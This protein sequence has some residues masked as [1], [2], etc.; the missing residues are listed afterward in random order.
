[1][2]KIILC[3]VFFLSFIIFCGCQKYGEKN[4][5]NDLEKKLKKTESYHITGVLQITNNDDTYQYDVDVS[6]KKENNYK[7]SLINKSNNHEQVILKNESGVYVVTPSLNKSFKFQSDWP[8]NNSQIYLLEALIADIKNDDKR[9]FEE[10]DNKY[11]FTTKVNYPNNSQLLKQQIQI[12][13]DLNIKKVEVLNSEDIPQM[14]MQFNN[15]DWNSNFNEDYF[16]LDN[17]IDTIDNTEI[18]AEE[19]TETEN[20]ND[21]NNVEADTTGTIDEIIFPLYIP[22]GTTLTGQEKVSKADGE[23]IILTFDGEKPFLLVEETSTIE[24]EFNIIPTFGEPYLIIDT[25]GALTD[26]SITWSSNGIDYYIVSDAMSQTELI[27]IASSISAI[28]TI[29]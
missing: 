26:N 16:D 15:I 27:E 28:P 13:K 14:I 3:A 29:K 24:D 10:K 5:I 7:V 2:K 18:N 1:M 12:D 19:N 20:N 17:I 6:Y 23:R 4:I 21:E 22:S 11:I 25:M 9:I 8:K